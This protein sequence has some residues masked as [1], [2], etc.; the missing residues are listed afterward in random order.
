MTPPPMTVLDASSGRAA[1]ISVENLAPARNQSPPA[2]E[3][4][5]L[6]NLISGFHWAPAGASGARARTATRIRASV[7]GMADPPRRPND[8]G[9]LPG[10]SPLFRSGCQDGCSAQAVKTARAIEVSCHDIG[11]MN[12]PRGQDHGSRYEAFHCFWVG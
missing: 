5:I 12:T 10:G 7:L 6:R 8:W 2:L 3:T 9:Q 11:A 1:G 4:P